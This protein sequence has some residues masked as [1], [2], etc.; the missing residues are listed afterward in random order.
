MSTTET[1]MKIDNNFNK[2][3]SLAMSVPEVAVTKNRKEDSP[4]IPESAVTFYITD[5]LTGTLKDDHNIE[6]VKMESMKIKYGLI[7]EIKE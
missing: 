2:D 3:L 5:S 6:Q 7:G 4:F 1:A